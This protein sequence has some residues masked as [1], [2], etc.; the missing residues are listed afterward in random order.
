MDR[1]LTRAGVCV[2][3]FAGN[4]ETVLESKDIHLT[5]LD[6]LKY[7]RDIALG[8]NWL[9]HSNPL[10]IHRGTHTLLLRGAPAPGF[11]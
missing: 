9:H 2:A 5:M 10:I 3:D 7:A 4:L 1:V 6:K 11:G 8:C